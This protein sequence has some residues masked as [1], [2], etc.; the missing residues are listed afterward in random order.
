MNVIFWA[1][2][3]SD[4]IYCN[5]K[6]NKITLLMM[7]Y[8]ECFHFLCFFAAQISVGAA[9]CA[10]MSLLSMRNRSIEKKKG[11]LREEEE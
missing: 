2:G 7:W 5:V 4:H 8:V 3:Y 11:K 9:R 6:F 10:S 1:K